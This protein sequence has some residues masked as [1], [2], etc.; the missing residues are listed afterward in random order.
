VLDI[1][2]G[3]MES[4]DTDQ[5]I[6]QEAGLGRGDV[7]EPTTHLDLLQKVYDSV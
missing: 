7:S 1:L 4:G 5:Y 2:G 3:A 6:F